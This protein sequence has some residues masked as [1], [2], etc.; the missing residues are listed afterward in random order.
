MS[1]AASEIGSST[2][3]DVQDAAP[4]SFESLGLCAE[5]CK[6]ARAVGWKAPSA[7]QAGAIPALLDPAKN[8]VCGARARA[9]RPALA[10]AAE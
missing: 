9:R 3:V 1:E 10:D 5:A 4:A 7:V 2:L 6:A 8:D